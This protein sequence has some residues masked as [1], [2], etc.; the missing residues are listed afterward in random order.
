MANEEK[1]NFC[2]NHFS[3]L[4]QRLQEANKI[5]SQF[6][7]RAKVQYRSFFVVV[8]SSVT[9]FKYFDEENDRLDSFFADFIGTDKSYADMW[10][11]CKIMP[12][13]AYGQ[14]SVERGFMVNTQFSIENVKGKSLIG[15][16]RVADHMSASEETPEE[17]HVTKNMLHY[18]KDV[19]QKHK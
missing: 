4:S 11:V 6:A 15:L 16:C 3:I 2:I 1:R 12:T 17:V 18:V 5:S 10:E 14:S 19:N 9:A 7:E 13:L 8:N